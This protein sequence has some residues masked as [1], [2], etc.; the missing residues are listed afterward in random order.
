MA[1][2]R[3]Q[4]GIDEAELARL[5]DGTLPDD[6]R[7][8][9]ERALTE[10]PELRARLAEQGRV[11]TAVRTAATSVAAPAG[12]RA[13]VAAGLEGR[14]R[15][16]ARRRRYAA[17]ALATAAALVVAGLLFALPSGG[18]GDPTLPQAAAI[19]AREPTD[20]PPAR[21]HDSHA[22]L[23][24]AAAGIPFPDWSEAFGWRAAGVRRDRLRGRELTTVYYE[25]DGHRIAYSIVSG[26][27][28][29]VPR[30]ARRA[31]VDGVEIA[32]LRL[33]GRSVVTWRREGHTCVLSGVGVPAGRLVPLAAWRASG[34]LPY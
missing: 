29:E 5:A 22:L 23:D 14:R 25:R 31:T 27:P 17:L 19:A 24:Q 13:R 28:L 20:P 30:S 21:Y 15:A 1:A 3:P 2:K 32:S 10:S 9:V 34:E 6:R 4:P 12:L 8:L 11:A 7:E 33:G 16:P 26:R 18:P